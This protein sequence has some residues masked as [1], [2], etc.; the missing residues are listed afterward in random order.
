MALGRYVVDAV[1][2][3]DLF[4]ENKV[5][6][7]HVEVLCAFSAYLVIIE[8]CIAIH[9]YSGVGRCIPKDN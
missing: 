7:E 5:W 6:L 4:S 2:P 8:M 9:S 1:S 3:N